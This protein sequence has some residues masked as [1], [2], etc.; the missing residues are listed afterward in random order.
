M[1]QNL[2]APTVG[3]LHQLVSLSCHGVVTNGHGMYDVP[4]SK[5]YLNC[6]VCGYYSSADEHCSL[7]DMTP[8]TFIDR[9]IGTKVL[10]ELV[11]SVFGGIR[12]DALL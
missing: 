6:R 8:C 12:E 9:Y 5:Y 2:Y 11:I 1:E 10:N 3:E 7:L 4:Y